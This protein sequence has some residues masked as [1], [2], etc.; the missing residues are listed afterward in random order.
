M[1]LKKNCILR[2][3]IASSMNG[4]VNREIYV[5]ANGKTQKVSSL[6]KQAR[7]ATLPE[8]Q[9][10]ARGCYSMIHAV[11]YCAVLCCLI[12]VAKEG[13][14]LVWPPASTGPHHMAIP[15]GDSCWG[16]LLF[17]FGCISQ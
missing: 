9:N 2:M 14:G 7:A 10:S 17:R 13:R 4:E 12:G 16:K 11:L 6:A 15:M 5:E 3:G 1:A 8:L